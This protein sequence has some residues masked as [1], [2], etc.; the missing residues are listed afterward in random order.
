[1]TTVVTNSGT[2]AFWY[3]TAQ[4]N[5]S[6]YYFSSQSG[7]DPSDTPTETFPGCTEWSKVS[8]Y[9]E[10]L[11]G[12]G[13]G[14]SRTITLRPEYPPEIT[15]EDTIY[16][17]RMTWTPEGSAIEP[18]PEDARDISGISFDGGVLSLVFTNADERFTYNLRGT[19]EL[20]AALSLWPVVWSTN[21]VGR[22]TIVPEIDPAQ[23][24]FFYYLET[25]TK[26]P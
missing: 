5:A 24:Q 9:I 17:D 12:Q 7:E 15:D 20:G 3:K 19:N 18:T 2:L 6:L 25:A 8:I 16:I 26:Q 23:S 4:G 22:I 11:K 1:M 10:I 13:Y 21:G 14:P